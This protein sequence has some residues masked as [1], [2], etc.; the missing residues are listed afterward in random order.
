MT[1]DTQTAAPPPP[2]PAAAAPSLL[3]RPIVRLGVAVALLALLGGAALAVRA[4][5]SGGAKPADATQQRSNAGLGAI[6]GGAPV[7]KQPA[8]DFALRSADGNVV[9][10]SDL[11]GKVVWVNF[12]ASWCVPCK[13]ELPD[14]QKL[15]DEKHAE[16]L[17]VL[18]INYEEDVAT[19]KDFFAQ[20]DVALPILMDTDG[21]VYDAYRLRGLPDSFFVDRDGNLQAQQFGYLTAD[22]MR[23]RLAAAGI[24]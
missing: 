22:T 18:T 5:R 7:L 1:Q 3:E 12:W 4:S 16:G 15:Y 24:Q 10:L 6:G 11:R 8:P 2:T 20:H 13:R 14:I 9:K 21:E 23:E 17:E 19:A